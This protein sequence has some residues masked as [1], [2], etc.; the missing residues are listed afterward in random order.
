[1]PPFLAV[2][3]T[4][5]HIVRNPHLKDRPITLSPPSRRVDVDHGQSLAD[6]VVDWITAAI[7]AGRMV[8]A[9]KLIEADI[10]EALGISRGPVR[11]ALKRLEAQGV[12][13]LSRHRGAYVH[14]FTRAETADLLVILE[15]LTAV[16]ARAAAEAVARGADGAEVRAAL[17]QLKGEGGDGGLISQ[18]RHFYDALIA[19][20]GNGQLAA[21]MPLMRIHL[22][23]LQVQPWFSADDLHDRTAEYAA[24]TD[25]VL[26]G[27]AKAA[28]RAM[29]HHMQR[30]TA[31]LQ[32]LPDAAFPPH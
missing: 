32:R 6:R 13:S 12:V 16:M 8:P 3:D 1:M 17:G 21:I 25:A 4:V 23:R 26:A 14:A 24:I 27:D 22:L 19:I 11:E 5:D 10:S 15:A 29:R 31:R 9:Q 20:G 2:P 28:E 30:M 18:R 7:L